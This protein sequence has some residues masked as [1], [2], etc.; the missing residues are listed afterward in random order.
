M[1]IFLF[2]AAGEV[3]KKYGSAQQIR[4]MIYD[5]K[6]Q[7]ESLDGRMNELVMEA[8]RSKERQGIQEKEAAAIQTE[9]LKNKSHS[10]NVRKEQQ[11]LEAY[12]K[13]LSMLEQELEISAE[14]CLKAE[15]FMFFS[16]PRIIIMRNQLFMASL[17][18]FECYVLR[19]KEPVL[20]N[21]NILLTAQE[22]GRGRGF[23]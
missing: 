1:F 4:D 15:A 5:R 17:S 14:Q 7:H 8:A 6:K 20:E 9:L 13:L 21:L 18:L 3:K 16:C 10:E 23:L 12:L 22:R 11:I 2:P 19:N